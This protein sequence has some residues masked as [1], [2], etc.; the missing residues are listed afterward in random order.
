MCQPFDDFDAELSCEDFEFDS[1]DADE[2][3]R[4]NEDFELDP[5]P[6]DWPE[7]D[8]GDMDGDFDTGMASA[9]LGTDE[10]YGG[11]WDEPEEYPW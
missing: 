2:R 3:E 11:G 10:D 7:A 5:D 6:A 1:V 9:D 8:P 4:I